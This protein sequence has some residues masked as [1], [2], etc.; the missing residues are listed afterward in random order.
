MKTIH[1][2][3]ISLTGTVVL[4]NRR[5]WGLKCYPVGFNSII[6]I[7]LVC[8]VFCLNSYK[9]PGGSPIIT[10]EM[11]FQT[12]KAMF[13]FEIRDQPFSEDLL[14]KCIY[15]ERLEYKDIVLLQSRLETGNYKSDIFL[16]G[17]NLFGMRFPRS[18]PTVATGSY[19]DHAQYSHWSESVMDYGL[20]Q[21]W[22]L[23]LG[24]RIGGGNDN[25]FYLV[26]LNCIPYAADPRYIPKLV[27]MSQSDV[28]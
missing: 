12:E 8:L 18:R 3:L 26:F 25:D 11:R 10:E 23:S 16:N 22:Y 9:V 7:I 17:N 21:K 1:K 20:W 19:K 27:A 2:I 13:Y 24:Y 14:K 5:I 15:Y 6:R 4:I 28:T